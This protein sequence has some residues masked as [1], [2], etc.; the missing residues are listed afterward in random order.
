MNYRS[1]IPSF[2]CIALSSCGSAVS[3][4]S[5]DDMSA[6]LMVYHS[7]DTHSLHMALSRDGYTFTA[8]NEGDPVVAGDTIALQHGIRDPHIYRGPDGAFYLAMTDL[9]IYAQHEGYRDT[10]W[11]RPY[12]E[13]AWG[14]NR[15]LV[16]MK[17]ND[18]INWKR[19]VVNFDTVP[20]WE[21]IGCA[22]APETVYDRDKDKLMVYLTMRHGRQPNKLY[23]TYVNDDFDR[24]E[25]EPRLLYVYPDSACSAID[26]DISYHDGKYY[27]HYVAHDGTPGIKQAVSDRPDGGWEYRADWIDTEDGACEA[28]NVWKR[29][30]EDRWVLMY[31]IYSISPHNFGFVETTDFETF[32][33]LGRFNEGPMKTVGFSSP[34]H[35]AV[36]HLTADEADRL[37]EYWRANRRPRRR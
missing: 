34:K 20:G 28:P 35:G 36:V 27:L 15:G 13:Y 30:G 10:E 11:E 12:E 21:D 18:L 8:L 17:S 2:L 24:I 3:I 33:P 25:T 4:P 26:G 14:N 9:H 7:D 22:W 16:L 29:I 6:Y 23:Y 37:E 32:E 1:I 5:E 31:D 19:S